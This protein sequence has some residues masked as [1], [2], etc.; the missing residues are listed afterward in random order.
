MR[1]RP[2][3]AGIASSRTQLFQYQYSLWNL[4]NILNQDT[5]VPAWYL[6]VSILRTIGVVVFSCVWARVIQ[7]PPVHQLWM[8]LFW[9]FWDEPKPFNLNQTPHWG[10]FFFFSFHLLTLPL[11]LKK[12]PH[13]FPSSF[14]FFSSF[15][16]FFS[17]A[18]LP[19]PFFFSFF[20]LL[21]HYQFF[22]LPLFSF[23]LSFF[24]SFATIF[25]SFIFLFSFFFFFSL[26][27]IFF[28]SIIAVAFFSS[29]FSLSFLLLLLLCFLFLFCVCYR[30]FFFIFVY[31]LVVF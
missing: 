30:F 27:T 16:F 13:F 15:V 3:K 18:T 12:I 1:T 20:L 25:F 4:P 8:R 14:F 24:F 17:F 2:Y 31:T 7:H 23:V 11:D 6:D 21:F 22:T 19:L 26:A 9:P 28:F 29:F 5:C 10:G